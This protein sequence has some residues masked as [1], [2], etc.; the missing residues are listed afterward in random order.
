MEGRPRADATHETSEDL[1]WGKSMIKVSLRS[2]QVQ[3]PL[4]NVHDALDSESLAQQEPG[5]CLAWQRVARL[6]HVECNHW[7]AGSAGKPFVA[8]TVRPCER[9][10]REFHA[11]ARSRS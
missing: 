7:R 1:P 11:F 8:L 3:A 9:M 4:G 2:F 5:G 10:P 6:F